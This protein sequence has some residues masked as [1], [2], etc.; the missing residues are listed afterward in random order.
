MKGAVLW[1]TE[2]YPEALAAAETEVYGFV[3]NIAM[4][5]VGLQRA[6]IGALI[7]QLKAAG[8]PQHVRMRRKSELGR[9]T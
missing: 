1:L 2:E 8:V 4:A 6:C 9:E 5:K 3:L 7:G